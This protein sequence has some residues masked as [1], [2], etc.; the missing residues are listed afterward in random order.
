MDIF[1]QGQAEA[2]RQLDIALTL[3]RG[4][5]KPLRQGDELPT[6]C[7]NGCGEAPAEGALYCGAECKSDFEDRHAKLRRQGFRG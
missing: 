6:T 4:K 5:S 7:I 2:E 1:D 3:A